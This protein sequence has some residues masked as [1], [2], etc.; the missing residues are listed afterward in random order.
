[1]WSITLPSGIGV[2]RLVGCCLAGTSWDI[3]HLAQ[4]RTLH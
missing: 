1:M 4:T 2:P 3:G